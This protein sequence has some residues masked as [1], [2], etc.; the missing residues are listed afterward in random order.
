M[1]MAYLVMAYIVMA[2]IAMAFMSMAYIVCQEG[3]GY[4]I[5]DGDM[6]HFKVRRPSFFLR[7]ATAPLRRSSP[8]FFSMTIYL[9]STAAY[10]SMHAEDIT[11]KSK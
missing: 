7:L 4:V 2:D 8:S 9:C 5:D 10:S 3:K 11:S 1:A 6:I